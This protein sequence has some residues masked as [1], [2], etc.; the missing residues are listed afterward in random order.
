MANS[1][2]PWIRQRS[3][4]CS[5]LT[6]S[7]STSICSMRGGSFGRRVN[8][9]SDYLVEAAHIA[10]AIDGRAPVKLQ[11]IR[12]D[13]MRGGY[14]RPF[15]V[16]WLRAGLDANGQPVAW[17]HRIVGQSI[18]QKGTAFES[19]MVQNGIDQTSVEGASNLPYDIPNLLVDLH[20]PEIG[21]PVQWWRSV[22]S[23]H[24]AFSTETFNRRARHRGRERHRWPSAVTCSRVTHATWACSISR[25]KRPVGGQSYTRAGHAG[26]RCM[27]R[28][29]HSLPRSPKSPSSL[30]A[31]S[32]LS[33]WYARWIA[34]WR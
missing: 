27:N 17:Q 21:V 6:P 34:G 32:R 30:M 29:T 7:R 9:Q 5:G 2:R 19:K 25:R 4:P 28:S 10:K 15:Y 14:Y 22:G 24:T 16:H 33:A 23:T 13:D 3:P 18:I 26:S 1:S 11:W 31:I 12:E 8:P 20:S